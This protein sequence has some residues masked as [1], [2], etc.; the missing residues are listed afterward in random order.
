LKKISGITSKEKAIILIPLIIV[1][2][3]ISLCFNYYVRIGNSVEDIITQEIKIQYGWKSKKLLNEITTTDFQLRTGN[4]IFQSGLFYRISNDF[5]KTYKE[6][7]KDCVEV[8]V[9]ID[10]MYGRYY[11]DFI[12]IKTPEGSFL[13]SDVLRDI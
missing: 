1:I 3:A 7:G 8:S 11:Q 12:L 13:I 5:M 9:V 2:L 6:S 10:D 4:S